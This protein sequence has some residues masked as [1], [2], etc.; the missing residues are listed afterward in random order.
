MFKI[1][2]SG[3]SEFNRAENARAGTHNNVKILGNSHY[4]A[5]GVAEKGCGGKGM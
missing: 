3:A 1:C 4:S 5:G 2:L